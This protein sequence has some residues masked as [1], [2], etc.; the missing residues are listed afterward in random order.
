MFRKPSKVRL[1]FFDDPG[2]NISSFEKRKCVKLERYLNRLKYCNNVRNLQK[3]MGIDS[4]GAGGKLPISAK[5]WV[6]R[7]LKLWYTLIPLA[8]LFPRERR[9]TFSPQ[10]QIYFHT[11]PG[12]QFFLGNRVKASWSGNLTHFAVLSLKPKTFEIN[13]INSPWSRETNG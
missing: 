10:L 2:V 11:F 5:V 9:P 8:G 1:T 13:V 4:W 12:T 7:F 3:L 6:Y